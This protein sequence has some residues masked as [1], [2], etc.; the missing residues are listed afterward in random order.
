MYIYE[1][2]FTYN[3]FTYTDTYT[4]TFT[5]TYTLYTFTCTYTHTYTWTYMY[6]YTHTYTDTSI[7]I[8]TYIRTCMYAYRH[9]Q[10]YKMA[11]TKCCGKGTLRPV[12]VICSLRILVV[13]WT[14][15]GRRLSINTKSR[16]T[17]PVLLEHHLCPCRTWTTAPLV[18]RTAS[19]F[20]AREQ[21]FQAEAFGHHCSIVGTFQILSVQ[22]LDKTGV[23][24]VCW[25]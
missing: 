16:C 22:E 15:P 2:S 25:Q 18:A 12:N 8:H 6:T 4:D 5:Y 17:L 11:A 7:H 24:L 20:R 19:H 3:T 9:T 10:T 14:S 23:S 21:M 1:Y 13:E